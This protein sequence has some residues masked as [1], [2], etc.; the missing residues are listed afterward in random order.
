MPSVFLARAPWALHRRPDLGLVALDVGDRDRR[1]HADMSQMR[2]VVLADDDLVGAL[3]GRLRVTFL[4]QHE[5]GL[6]RGLLELLAVGDRVVFA[7]G[8]VVPH[9]LQRVAALDCRTGVARDHGDAA[10]RLEF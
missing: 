5:A 4:A 1:L 3:Q 6:A 2:E 7:V 8:A 9:Q 10:E